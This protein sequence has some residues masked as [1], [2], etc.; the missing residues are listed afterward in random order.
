MKVKVGIVGCGVV[1]TGVVELLLK[2]SETIRKKTGIELELTKVADIDWE[3]PRSF[4]VPESLRTTDYR[5]VIE[6]SHIVV[7]L[8]GGKG[9]AREL[10]KKALQAGK[11]VV[12][13]NKHLLA[14]EG[15]E[16]FSLAEE[17]GL[18]IGFE[19]SVG[20][21]IPIIK[22]IR[23]SLLGNN[24]KAVYGILNGTT[25]YILTKMLEENMD[26]EKAL[27]EAQEKGYAEADPSLDIDGWDSAHKIA[28][29]SYIAFGGFFPF[30]GVYVEG[31]RHVDL[32]DVMLG[33]EL[34]YTLK[35]LAIA[36][37]REEEIEVRVHPTFLP[38]EDPLAKVSDV[39]NAITVEGDF[40][41]KTMF[42]GRGAGSH[43]TASA[44]VA[45]IVD[46]ACR[47]NSSRLCPLSVNWEGK[48][49]RL[50]EDFYSRY[51]LRFDVPDRPGVLASI[52]RVLAD[53]HISIASVL[54]KEKVYR[55]AGKEKEHIGPLVIL[56]HKAYEKSM[57][58]ALEEIKKL[59]VVVGK[60]VVIR[61]EEEAE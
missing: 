18:Y 39:F 15:H 7:E 57:R 11:H 38:E 37:R 8:V 17:K 61:V 24:I 40:V 29:L 53:H 28:I 34:G 23:E 46:I 27:R 59:P 42:Y 12:T 35:L 9:F 5:E 43:P 44:V 33:K 16:L 19:A 51:Y 47:I 4:H 26:F 52:A 41:G 58:K 56:T 1:G 54:Q 48:D 49:L 31:I 20:G 22:A 25:N 30:S 6:Q 10:V 13:A 14:E 50:A 21:G 32:L 45:D 60:P 3:K 36:K 55:L 2:N